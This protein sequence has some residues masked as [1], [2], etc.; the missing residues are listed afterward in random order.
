MA[1]RAAAIMSSAL[2]GWMGGC[3]TMRT[4][5]PYILPSCP[6]GMSF[7]VPSSVTGTTGTFALAATLNAPCE[8]KP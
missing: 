6:L 3:T 4:R 1:C 5:P 8:M 2:P 7:P